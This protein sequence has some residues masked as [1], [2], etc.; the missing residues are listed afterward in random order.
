M[1]NKELLNVV[2]NG[3]M[4]SVQYGR[5]TFSGTI[6]DFVKECKNFVDFAKKPNNYFGFAVWVNGHEY[7][8]ERGFKSLL[9]NALSSGQTSA[10]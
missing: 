1:T 6:S 3:G 7:E 9:L 2:I 5:K 8:V 10:E 4:F